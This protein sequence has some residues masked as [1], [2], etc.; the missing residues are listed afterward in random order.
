MVQT[1][2]GVWRVAMVHDVPLRLQ[3]RSAV[4]A[5]APRSSLTA[6]HRP[7]SEPRHGGVATY[8]VRHR[9][10][11]NL[12]IQRLA[13][14]QLFRVAPVY[15]HSVSGTRR[16]RI[17]GCFAQTGGR[18]ALAWR[19]RTGRL[20]R[21]SRRRCTTR[22]RLDEARSLHAEGLRLASSLA[23]DAGLPDVRGLDA[24]KARWTAQILGLTS[25][26]DAAGHL[27]LSRAPAASREALPAVS[28]HVGAR[29]RDLFDQTWLASRSSTDQG[30]HQLGDR[31]AIA[32]DDRLAAVPAERLRAESSTT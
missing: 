31:E 4:I 29:D 1:R 10:S 7:G 13:L 8:F 9:H 25:A 5:T 16:S 12:R 15:R 30:R 20:L 18:G 19:V 11:P 22:S 32:C 23:L 24:R 2:L 17:A 27:R 6:R 28:Q 26:P 3:S 14:R 21:C